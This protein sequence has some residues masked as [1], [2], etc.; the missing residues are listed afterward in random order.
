MKT[1]HLMMALAVTFSVSIASAAFTA[2]ARAD[3]GNNKSLKEQIK[4]DTK[5]D[6]KK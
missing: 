5:K 1:N 3:D 6:V 4:D 2:P